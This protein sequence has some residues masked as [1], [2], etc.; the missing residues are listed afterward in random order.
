MA[1]VADSIADRKQEL[2]K[3][4]EQAEALQEKYKGKRWEKADRERFDA[5]CAEGAEIQ[6]ELESE[7]KAQEL[8]RR[9]EMLDR[10]P[11]PNLPNSRN[12][13]MKGS[14]G[15]RDVVGYLSLGES[16]IA[17]PE[18]QAYAKNGYAR[19]NHAVIQLATAMLGKNIVYG[20]RGEPMV[21]ITAETR[22]FYHQ[23]LETREAKAVPNLGSGVIDADRIARVPKVTMDDRLR[24][25]DVINQGTTNG[26]TVEYVR[27]EAITGAAAPTAHGSEK[28]ELGVQYTL[29]TAP[30]RTIAGWMPVQNQ[31]LEDWSQ[32]RSL[33]DG[34]LRYAVQRAEE[35]QI[36]FG[37]GLGPNLTGI[38]TVPGTVDIAA[39]GRSE[40]G[41][42]LIDT[43]R[44]GITDVFV[45]GYEPNAVVLHPFDWE[46]ILLAKGTDERYVW[47][48]VTDNNGSRIWGLRVVESVGA[49]SR[50]TEVDIPRRVIIVGDWQMGAQ[51]LDRMALTVQVGLVDR[52]FVENMRTILAEERIAL[53]IYAPGAFAFYETVAES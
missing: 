9:S 48:V 40:V 47:A 19:G 1:P 25:R 35:E 33:I 44:R 22:K 28:P 6:S 14:M 12:G 30:V 24:I 50:D 16:V 18:F 29:Q 41:D 31:Q 46:Q 42:T 5:L 3:I 10:I 34:R 45:N 37:D 32:L 4:M 15:P 17:S 13:G 43:I 53:P 11:E 52:Q 2:D 20:P 49:Q 8:F 21:P 23:F 36:I 51:L 38:M 7:Q 39:N 26:G 27:E